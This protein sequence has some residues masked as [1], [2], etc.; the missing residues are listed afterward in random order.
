MLYLFHFVY[1]LVSRTF[2]VVVAWY[3]HA[4]EPANHQPEDTGTTPTP[5]PSPSSSS[6]L[7]LQSKYHACMCCKYLV[8]CASRVKTCSLPP[9][10]ADRVMPQVTM[11]Q[12]MVTREVTVMPPVITVTTIQTQTI[13][14]TPNPTPAGCTGTV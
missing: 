1:L 11:P 2:F 4:V 3:K 8:L 5:S 10:F 7:P 14:Y 6:C 9:C 12:A 13:T